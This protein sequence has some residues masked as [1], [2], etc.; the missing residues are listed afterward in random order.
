M[1]PD[2]AVVVARA[3]PPDHLQVWIVAATPQFGQLPSDPFHHSVRRQE[4]PVGS[5]CHL[6]E[7]R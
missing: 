6:P 7:R 1:V 5:E 2:V 4:V 3:T